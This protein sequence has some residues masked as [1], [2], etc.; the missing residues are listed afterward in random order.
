MI[1]LLV[2]CHYLCHRAFHTTGGLSHAGVPSGVAFGVL[3]ELENLS[4]MYSPS[5]CILAFDHPGKGLRAIEYP[6]YKSSRRNYECSDEEKEQL[7]MFREE[8]NRLRLE[9]L[10]ELGYRNVLCE[11]G[12]EADDIIAAFAGQIHVKDSGVIVSSD[13]DLLQCLRENVVLYNPRTKKVTTSQSFREEWGIYPQMWASVKALAGCDSDDVVGIRGIGEK[14]AA[15]WF[16][17]KLKASSAAYKK[18]SE[19][20][21]VY[22]RN[23]DLVRLPYPGLELPEVREDEVTEARRVKMNLKLGIR[24]R[25]PAKR[26]PL[27][28]SSGFDI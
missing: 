17:G 22:N 23:I 6:E 19:N 14:T 15:K 12:Y 5:R 2:D 13:G 24:S 18:I 26:D 11:K 4:N 8:V 9:I 7:E 16:S 20:L 25:A 10:P 1:W 21:D 3:R 28:Q 27:R